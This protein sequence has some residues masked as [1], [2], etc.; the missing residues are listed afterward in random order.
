MV[1][2]RL[3]WHALVPF[4]GPGTELALDIHVLALDY[5]IVMLLVLECHDRF[6]AQDCYIVMLLAMLLAATC[7]TACNTT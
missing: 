7:N 5:Y 4:L 2:N 6:L 1:I 3:S